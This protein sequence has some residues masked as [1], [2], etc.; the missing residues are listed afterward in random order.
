[1]LWFSCLREH[2]QPAPLRYTFRGRRR[3]GTA[4]TFDAGVSTT[5]AGDQLLITTVVR[6]MSPAKDRVPMT[7]IPGLQPLSS[8]EF[9]VV[10][11]LVAGRRAKEIAVTMQISE[12]TVATYRHRIYQKL[13]LRNELDLF[14]F[15]VQRRLLDP[16]L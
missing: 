2:G 10:K 16:L 14:R 1:M 5:R 6:E 15:A 13:A 3:D 7:A 9:A 4:V 11:H 12:K 8:R